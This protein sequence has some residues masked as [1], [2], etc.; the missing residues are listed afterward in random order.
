MDLKGALMIQVRAVLFLIGLTHELL[1]DYKSIVHGER[2]G[3]RP[4]LDFSWFN[5]FSF[6][7][8]ESAPKAQ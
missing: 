7:A 1:R 4:W 8:H 2:Q 5:K 6:L 3:N